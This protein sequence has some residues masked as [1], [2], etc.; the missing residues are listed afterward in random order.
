MHLKDPTTHRVSHNT[1]SKSAAS[2]TN[3]KN[4]QVSM[5]HDGTDS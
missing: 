4:A 2:L 3:L 1:H 5:V